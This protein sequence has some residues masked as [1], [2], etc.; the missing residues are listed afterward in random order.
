MLKDNN[1]SFVPGTDDT[2][3]RV[4]PVAL[5][6]R[7]VGFFNDELDVL[8]EGLRQQRDDTPLQRKEPEQL[9]KGRDAWRERIN[10]AAE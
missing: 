1:D 3:R 9:R 5:G 8:I 6:S 4:R 2:V 10:S 7:A